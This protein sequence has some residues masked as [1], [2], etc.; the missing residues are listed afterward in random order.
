MD[1]HSFFANPDPA[2]FLCADLDPA[3]KLCKKISYEEFAV[4]EKKLKKFLKSKNPGFGII[5]FLTIFFAF[6]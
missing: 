2:V 6:S 4:V 1:L 5:F 3:L